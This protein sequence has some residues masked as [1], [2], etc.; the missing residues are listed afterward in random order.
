[1]PIQS[2]NPA[3]GEILKDYQ[4]LSEDMIEQKLAISEDA[5]ESWKKSNINERVILFGKI[6][7]LLK[8][9]SR[10][11]GEILTTEVGKPIKSAIAEVEKC[12][13]VFEFYAEEGPKFL[14]SQ[15]VKTDASESFV[16]FDPLG[17]ILAVMPWNFPFW[18]VMRFAAPTIMAGN[19]ALLK[20]ASNVPQ[21]SEMLAQLFADAGFPKGVFQ[22]LLIGSSKVDA[23]I[24]DPRIKAITL[25]GSEYAGSKVAET[26][27]SQIKKTLLEL[28]GSDPFIV[29]GDADLEFTCN[30]AVNA[31]LQNN[32]QSCIAA[33]RFIIVEEKYDEFIAKY[34][35]A[36]EMLKVGDPMLEDTNVGPLVNEQSL[37][38]I[39][40]Q[41]E[42]SIQLGAK[43]IT[44]GKRIGTK[45]FYLQPTILG[46]VKKGMPAY[47]QEIFGPVAAVIK[48]KDI[49]EAIR[50]ANDSQFGLG[51]SIWTK[52]IS[53][54]KKMAA[55]IEAG[56]VF[57]NGV[58]KSDPRLPFGGIKK[59]GYGRE[60][61]HY[62]MHEFVNIKTVW[63]K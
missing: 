33:K 6:S 62:G 46:E 4:E 48:V 56:N 18:Q 37:N 30:Q 23:L 12:A 51:S 22:N 2:I 39:L 31:R 35:A 19:V 29:L 50:V 9:R 55:E 52:D 53:L 21:S 11:L 3:T 47:D 20:H 54:A 63:I 40:K 57:I 24:R 42:D 32:G 61:S 13:W 16:R 25:T 14:E 1:M 27:G 17:A 34:K 8:E 26:A 58:V 7:K 10:E 59:S 28:G 15:L 43:L 45:G 44:G 36:Y 41:I 38:E 5:F 49:E 60:L